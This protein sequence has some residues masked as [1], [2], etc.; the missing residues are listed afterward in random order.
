MGHVAERG[1]RGR[2]RDGRE[3]GEREGRDRVCVHARVRMHVCMHGSYDDIRSKH[4][5]Y[6]LR[7][8]TAYML[9]PFAEKTCCT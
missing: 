6:A 2:E 9:V 4:E 5:I 7:T 8:M 3:I 1:E